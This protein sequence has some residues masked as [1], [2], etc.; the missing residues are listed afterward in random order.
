MKTVRDPVTAA[1]LARRLGHGRDWLYRNLDRLVAEDG[2]PRPL[3]GGGPRMEE[4]SAGGATTKPRLI[5]DRASIEAWFAR[6]HPF[7]HSPSRP[8]DAPRSLIVGAPA[9]D[10]A[11]VPVPPAEDTGAWQRRLAEV[12]GR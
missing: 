2:L 12:Y 5:F 8:A 11:P 9:N 4:A 3:I 1:E 6:H 10:P 7:F